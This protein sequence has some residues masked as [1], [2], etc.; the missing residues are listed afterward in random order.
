MSYDPLDTLKEWRKK[1]KL[2]RKELAD[3]SNIDENTIK[4][5]EKGIN[6]PRN[7]KLS[8]LLTLCDALHIKL[9]QLFPN[10]KNIA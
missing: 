4:S 9:K 2:T 8:T 6:N 10:E 1:R 3:I 7:A 5:I